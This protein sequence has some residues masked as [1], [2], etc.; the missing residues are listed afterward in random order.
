MVPYVGGRLL[1]YV[2]VVSGAFVMFPDDGSDHPLFAAVFG[3][4]PSNEG[5]SVVQNVSVGVQVFGRGRC[6]EC[7]VD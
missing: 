2:G 7:E 3:H 6:C 1:L 5:D 4:H